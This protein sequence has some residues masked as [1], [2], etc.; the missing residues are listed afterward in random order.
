MQQRERDQTHDRRRGDQERV[1]DFPA[2]QDG[3][4]DQPDQGGQPITDG[5][6][7]QQDACSQDR[8]D[9]CRI[10]AFD[11]SLHIEIAAMAR[12]QWSGDEDQEE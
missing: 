2:K 5:D 8:P 9:R 7:S 3:E 11:K 12:E 4:R 6:A 1:A 10:G